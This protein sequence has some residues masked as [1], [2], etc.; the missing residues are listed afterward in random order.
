[1]VGAR[2]YFPWSSIRNVY[3]A[4]YEIS[5]AALSPFASSAGTLVH[6]GLGLEMGDGRRHTV[7]F[8]PGTIRAFRT[9]SEGFTYAMAA[10]RDAFRILGRPLVS[11]VVSYTD[12]QVLAMHEEARKPLLG[13]DAIVYAFFLPPAIFAGILLVLVSA[14]A[15]IGVPVLAATV[16]LALIPPVSSMWFTLAKSRR[17]NWVLSELAKYE[18]AARSPPNDA[19]RRG[20]AEL[21]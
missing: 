9:E 13:L 21:V 6:T 5:G 10:V 14:G 17:R 18:E 11:D 12:A 16:G 15:A 1:M 4:S 20:P 19:N 2:V 3:P 8:T 7:R